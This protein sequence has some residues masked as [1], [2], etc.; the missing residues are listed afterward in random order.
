MIIVKT[1]NKNLLIDLENDGEIFKMDIQKYTE[2][3]YWH[4]L[5]FTS[6]KLYVAMMYWLLISPKLKKEA[7][8]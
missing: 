1:T 7:E 5:K 4:W 2:Y 8:R 3:Y 6:W